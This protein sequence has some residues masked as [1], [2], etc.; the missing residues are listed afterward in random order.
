MAYRTILA[1]VET[2]ASGTGS[3]AVAATLARLNA[4]R[5]VGLHVMPP[6]YEA[7]EQ[8][9]LTLPTVRRQ[10]EARRREAAAAAEAAFRHAAGDLPQ[11]AW[12]T[13][14]AES[15]EDLQRIVCRRA[16]TADL[17]VVPQIGAGERLEDAPG[18][19]PEALVMQAG[20]PVLVVPQAGQFPSIGRRALVAWNQSREAS[21]AL[22]DAMPFLEAAEEVCVLTINETGG[23]HAAGSE[24]PRAAQAVAYLASHGVKA[25]AL[26]DYATELRAGDLLLS[27]ASDLGADLL[28]L[29]A[30]GH[31]RLREMVLGGVTRDILQHMT[32]P[33]LMSH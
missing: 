7:A 26:R 12:E 3:L 30:Y 32:V 9:I 8:A 4:A 2:A 24:D 33:V 17:I 15:N 18:D 29:G 14:A 19:L 11:A 22:A 6:A 10:I 27:R 25:K 21:R 13:D 23:S 16:R 31:S 5:L 28:V 20:R 1:P